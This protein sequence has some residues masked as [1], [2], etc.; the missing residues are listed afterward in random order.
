MWSAGTGR[1]VQQFF[2]LAGTFKLEISDFP[3]IEAIGNRKELSIR[4]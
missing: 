3:G 4:H 2:L 1:R